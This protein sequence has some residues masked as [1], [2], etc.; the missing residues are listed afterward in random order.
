MT[1][2]APR[3]R[4]G[5]QVGG[6]RFRGEGGR[7]AKPDEPPDCY[8]HPKWNVDGSCAVSHYPD[9]N[10]ATPPCCRLLVTRVAGESDIEVLT[11]VM[12]LCD[13]KH[14]KGTP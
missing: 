4:G 2:L 9:D 1:D 3:P 8:D 10:D 12:L 11:R 7:E 5:W 14:T 13:R 6:M